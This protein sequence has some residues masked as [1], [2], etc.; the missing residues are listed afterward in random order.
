VAAVATLTEQLERER[1]RSDQAEA[2]LVRL[3]GGDQLRRVEI[4]ATKRRAEVAEA[5]LT[6]L[7][8]ADQARRARGLLARV[9]AALKGA[10][11]DGFVRTDR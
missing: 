10:D 3:R 4:E 8:E 11:I 1:G 6:R 2:E 5:E 7:R 9:R